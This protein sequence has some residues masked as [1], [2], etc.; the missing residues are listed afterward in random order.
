MVERRVFLVIHNAAHNQIPATTAQGDWNAA[1][2]GAPEFA[3]T[4]APTNL[5]DPVLLQAVAIPVRYGF[6]NE[7]IGPFTELIAVLK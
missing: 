3:A 2:T 4:W 7:N 5:F 1:G 6:N